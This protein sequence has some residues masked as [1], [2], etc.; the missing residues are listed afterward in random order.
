MI[1]LRSFY[2][3]GRLLESTATYNDLIREFPEFNLIFNTELGV[4]TAISS[5]TSNQITPDMIIGELNRINDSG[6]LQKANLLENFIDQVVSKIS[7]DKQ[8][9]DIEKDVKSIAQKIQAEVKKLTP[10]Y[11]KLLD[12]NSDT[13]VQKDINNL[14]SLWCEINSEIIKKN[15]A[16]TESIVLER[17]MF[18]VFAEDLVSL[19]VKVR[20][21]LSDIDTYLKNKGI[22]ASSRLRDIKSKAT[23]VMDEI[24]DGIGYG[25]NWDNFDRGDAKKRIAVLN[26]IVNDLTSK[27]TEIVFS[28]RDFSDE[29]GRLV[30]EISDICNKINSLVKQLTEKGLESQE[31]IGDIP[32]GGELAWDII[33]PLPN[34]VREVIGLYKKRKWV[35]VSGSEE[36]KFTT[37]GVGSSLYDNTDSYAKLY[38]EQKGSIKREESE[39]FVNE[40]DNA[41]WEDPKWVKVEDPQKI[42]FFNKCWQYYL[43]K[44]KK[45]VCENSKSLID[46]SGTP[47]YTEE[48]H[49]IFVP[50][51]NDIKKFNPAAE[52]E[53]LKKYPNYENSY[54]IDSVELIPDESGGGGEESSETEDNESY[55]HTDKIK[56][57]SF[58]GPRGDNYYNNLPNEIDGGPNR[59][60]YRGSNVLNTKWFKPGT[61]SVSPSDWWMRVK[62]GIWEYCQKDTRAEPKEGVDDTL[63]LDQKLP[64]SVIS[65]AVSLINTT[66]DEL[67]GKIREQNEISKYW[68][69][70]EGKTN[71]SLYP[72]GA[73]EGAMKV[74]KAGTADERCGG[75]ISPS[76]WG[77]SST[78][79]DVILYFYKNG[80]F[81]IR[82]DD[83]EDNIWGNWGI[84]SDSDEFYIKWD[85]YSTPSTRGWKSIQPGK[86]TV[87]GVTMFTCPIKDGLKGALDK[88]AIRFMDVFY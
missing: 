45:W 21:L 58:K 88:A 17:N 38:K 70:G 77:R 62:N 59:T 84:D 87:G 42:D 24:T 11:D 18:E 41:D 79:D 31:G 29:Y 53:K 8:Y 54:Y 32:S 7:L 47:R 36:G 5:L 61:F 63:S 46:S 33:N 74:E 49:N 10:K 72:W 44:Q 26:T 13:E 43:I 80:N 22:R 76:A 60:W 6:V 37:S 20:S 25:Q 57:I 4:I 27:Y 67:S 71:I 12:L 78:Y 30:S 69:K 83:Y 68:G 55:Y 40:S 14:L 28:E 64:K 48:D 75:E 3:F 73:S 52:L 34:S 82:D 85:L 19:R 16:V 86:G 81:E 56:A 65:D 23:D 1:K 2:G 50:S 9:S 39:W 15:T 35:T 51:E 66:N